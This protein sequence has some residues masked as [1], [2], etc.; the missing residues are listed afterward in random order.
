LLDEVEADGFLP[1]AAAVAGAAF[2]PPEK[3]EIDT[4]RSAPDHLSNPFRSDF[5]GGDLSRQLL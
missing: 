4:T 2:A 1:A 3:N 5:I